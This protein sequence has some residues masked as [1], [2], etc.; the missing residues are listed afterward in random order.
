MQPLID[1]RNIT[2]TF[3][4]HTALD[5]VTLSLPPGRIGLLGPNGAGKSTL[6][7]VLMGLIPPSSGTGRV[8]DEELG[9]DR[10][11]AGNWRLR[12][13][14]G[15]MPEADALVPGLTGVEY[16]SLAGELYGMPRREAQRRA[17]EVLSYLELEEA[18]YR[19]VEEYSTGMKQR[20][21]L[22]QAVVHDPPVLL[23]DEPT[24]GLDPAGRDAILRLV[25]N[26]G[27]E[28]G[29][30]VLLSTHLLADVEAVC[31]RVVIL[32]GGR[33]RG[34]GTVA[35]LCSRRQDRYRI[36][37]QGEAAA[38][39]DDLSTEG[40]RVLEDNGQ[41]EWRV[42]VPEGW[43]NLAFFKLADVNRVVIRS[44]V[45]DD[46]TLEELFLRTVGA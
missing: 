26:L 46:E 6:L 30:S 18:R 2:R 34:V 45:R 20:A 22:A 35:E 4:A 39:R 1:L 32:A 25:R 40:V 10:D 44:L 21:K 7:K 37:V 11:A 9:G 29:K 17:H 16:V 14:I 31:E 13:L 15:F 8:L 36:R 27:T 33:V 42:A 19:R 28:H 38:F 43:S 5:D 23:L 41:G 3:G 24:S 12:R